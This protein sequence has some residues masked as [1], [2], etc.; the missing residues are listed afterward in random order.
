MGSLALFP[1]RAKRRHGFIDK[2]IG[3]KDSDRFGVLTIEHDNYPRFP[4][5]ATVIFKYDSRENNCPHVVGIDGGGIIAVCAFHSN[6]LVTVEPLRPDYP[7]I[8]DTESNLNILGCI[9][10]LYSDPEMTHRWVLWR[11]WMDSLLVPQEPATHSRLV[12]T[13]QTTVDGTVMTADAAC[14]AFLGLSVEQ[15]QA[16]AWKAR[17]HPEDRT[18]YISARQKAIAGGTIYEN[19]IRILDANEEYRLVSIALVPI[20][21]AR[22]LL[23][24]WHAVARLVEGAAR[25]SA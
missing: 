9:T 16:G 4:M 22:G 13:W 20:R 6:G 23:I 19:R 21:D 7:T 2:P 14:Q 12:M 8:T 10:D 1:L 15:M 17:I 24:G 5:G 18:G 3:A 11:G 25:Q